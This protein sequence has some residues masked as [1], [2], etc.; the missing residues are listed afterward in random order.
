ML[1]RWGYPYVFALW[2][3]HITLSRR[4]DAAEMAIARPAAEAHFAAA[5]AQPRAV[6]S[7]AI[8]TQRSAASPF[9]IA[10]KFPLAT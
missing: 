7:L 3:F 1:E 6:S 2:R 9:L 10:Q 4:L 5:L 8:F